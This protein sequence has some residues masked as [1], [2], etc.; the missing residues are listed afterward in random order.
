MVIRSVLYRFVPELR[1]IFNYKGNMAFDM[2]GNMFSNSS[3]EE[4]TKINQPY[5][6]SDSSIGKGTYIGQN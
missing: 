4:M 5:K 1:P 3:K 2:I 6:V